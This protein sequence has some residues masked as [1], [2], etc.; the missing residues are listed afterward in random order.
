MFTEYKEEDLKLMIKKAYL[1]K[2]GNDV[3]DMQKSLN[4]CHRKIKELQ[5]INSKLVNQLNS[6]Q[7]SNEYKFA[8]AIKNIF[9]NE[10]NENLGNVH[11]IIKEDIKENLSVNVDSKYEPYSGQ[12]DHYH[13]TTVTYGGEIIGSNIS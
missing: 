5:D 6:I 12:Q 10:I 2:F 8:K 7:S 9:K 1:S 13:E 11:D 4:D 3:I